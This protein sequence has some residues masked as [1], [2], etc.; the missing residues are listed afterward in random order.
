MARLAKSTTIWSDD[1]EF[2]DIDGLVNGKKPGSLKNASKSRQ[3]QNRPLKVEE[4]TKP[5]STVRRR[6]LGPL[7]DNLLLRAWIPDNAED[8]GERRNLGRKRENIEPRRTRVEL[9]TR[10]SK[11]AAALASSPLQDEE[12][13]SAQEEVTIIEDV[14]MFDGTFHSCNSEA[15]E[16]SEGSES[17]EGSEYSGSESVD[18]E[19]TSEGNPPPT[20]LRVKPMLRKADKKPPRRTNE[21][22]INDYCAPPKDEESRNRPGSDGRP[23]TR[24]HDAASKPERPQKGETKTQKA[25]K[26]LADSMAKLRL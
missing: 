17:L 26:E 20:R 1:D 10:K 2:P 11:P 25:T 24:R 16:G 22:T 3:N 9:R 7:T 18:E 12:Y 4:P 19:E 8:D 23:S 5:A 21:D 13:V 15:S 14:S 6:K